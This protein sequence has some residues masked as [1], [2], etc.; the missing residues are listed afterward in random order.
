MD[1]FRIEETAQEARGV[2][3]SNR[4]GSPTAQGSTPR[5]E[6]VVSEATFH[7]VGPSARADVNDRICEGLEVAYGLV[8][9]AGT[10]YLTGATVQDARILEAIGAVRAL[11]ADAVERLRQTPPLRVV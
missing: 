9:R 11:L 2:A 5:S 3:A 6:D 7:T 4:G 10:L 1:T 8:E